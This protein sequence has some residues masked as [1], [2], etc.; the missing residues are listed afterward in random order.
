[1]TES[2]GNYRSE[3]TKSAFFLELGNL[4]PE[5]QQLTRNC[6]RL[7]SRG[8]YDLI[9]ALDSSRQTVRPKGIKRGQ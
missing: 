3:T 8:L 7:L 5:N 6:Q 4:A 2:I 1:M 9:F